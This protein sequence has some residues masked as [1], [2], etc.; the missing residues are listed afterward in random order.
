MGTIVTLMPETALV[1]FRTLCLFLST[2]NRYL[3][4]LQRHSFPSIFEHCSSFNSPMAGV[5]IS[6]SKF[7]ICTPLQHGLQFLII[8]H[9]YLLMN[10]HVVQFQY[11][12]ELRGYVLSICTDFP[13]YHRMESLTLKVEH[14]PILYRNPD[15]YHHEDFNQHNPILYHERQLLESSRRS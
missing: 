3:F 1:S 11:G 10:L 2:G 4:L 6:Q 12:F 13:R 9:R 8:G 5:K 15:Y 14:H 7:L